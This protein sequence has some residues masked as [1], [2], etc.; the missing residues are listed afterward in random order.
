MDST[1]IGCFCQ[2]V[3]HQR[4]N[5]RFITFNSSCGQVSGQSCGK[6]GSRDSAKAM[7]VSGA[8]EINTGWDKRLPGILI[9]VMWL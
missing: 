6:R 9:L 7:F 5:G 4:V 1:S 8:R 2:F 3:M